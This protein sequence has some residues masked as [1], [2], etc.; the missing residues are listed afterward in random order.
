MGQIDRHG[1]G[2]QAQRGWQ[3]GDGQTDVGQIDTDVGQIDMGQIDRH[4]TGRTAQRGW[5][6]GEG[7]GGTGRQ[8]W[9]R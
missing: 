2:R 1:T 6:G 9:N 5:L 7:G 3:G 8:T 4:G